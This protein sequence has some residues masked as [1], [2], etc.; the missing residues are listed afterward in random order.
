MDPY[1]DDPYG[2]NDAYDPYNDPN[3]IGGANDNAIGGDSSE[4]GGQHYS[5]KDKEGF[6]GR[7]SGNQDKKF[8]D[9]DPNAAG[10]EA[11]SKNAARGLSG[12]EKSALGGN[13]SKITG[14]GM[15]G[16]RQGEGNVESSSL[17]GGFASKVTGGMPGVGKGKGKGKGFI[18]KLG[19]ILIA[20]C[21]LG[22][23]GAISFFGQMA[24]PFSLIAQFQGNFDSIGTSNYSRVKRFTK[25]IMHGD[26]RTIDTDAHKYIKKHSKVYQLFADDAENYFDISPKQAKRLSRKGKITVEGKGY[27]TYLKF[28]QDNGEFVEVV[29]DPARA[30]GGRVYID[31][32]YETDAT[33]RTAYYEG[34]KTWRQSVANWFDNLC[35]NFLKRIGIGRN[36]FKTYDADQDDLKT[37][38]DYEDT[39]K[40]AT[41]DGDYDGHAEGD[42][43]QNK[44][45]WVPD[46]PDNPDGPG[47]W[48]KSEEVIENT[49]AGG[50]IGLK[51]GMDEGTVAEKIRDYSTRI[52]NKIAGVVKFSKI[53]NTACTIAEII[54]AVSML[55]IANEALQVLQVSTTIFEGVQKS[56]LNPDSV[57]SPI[58]NISNSLTKKKDTKYKNVKNETLELHGSAMEANAVSALY[59]NMATDPTDPSVNSF[60]L[61]DGIQ[62]AFTSYGSGAN[63]DTYKACL[64]AKLAG[65]LIDALGDAISL[66]GDIAAIIACIGGALV[67][68][69]GSCAALIGSIIKHVVIGLS[70]AAAISFAVA[71]VV[72]FL[73]PKIATMVGRDLAKDIGGE[74]FGNALVSGANMYMGKNHQSGG[75]AAA[76][77]ETLITYLKER[78][79][80]VA[81]I[82]QHERDTRSPFDATSPY[83]FMGSLLSSTIPIL[84]S[85]GSVISSISNISNVTTKAFS[86]LMPGASAVTAAKTAQAAADSTHDTCPELDSIGAVGDAFCNPYRVTDF[87]LMDDDPANIVYDVS[88]LGNGNNFTDAEGDVPMINTDIK[89]GNDSSRLMEYIV[90][91][92]ERDSPLGMTDMN[93]ANSIDAGADTVTSL[94]PV[95]GGIADVLQGTHILEKIG[96]VSGESCVAQNTPKNNVGSKAFDWN[97]AKY[98][99]RFIEDQRYLETSG[100]VEKSSVTIA[101]EKY[102][103]EHP[104]DT[105]YEGVMARM[106]GMTKEKVIATEDIIDL[107]MWIAGYEPDGYFP[108]HYEEPEKERIAIE[109]D[110]NVVDLE[111]YNTIED[112]SWLYIKKL[113]YDIS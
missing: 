3:S 43:A 18:G 98:Y 49:G 48:E 17:G 70:I 89:P 1:G 80:Y 16:A 33:F 34:T 96:Y 28:R 36:R 64:I 56:Q 9:H 110:D 7:V 97:E 92:D 86:S 101:L 41:G 47:H 54:G 81:D 57:E 90:Y 82:A 5:L 95:W 100:R 61:T 13:G 4:G 11:R 55:V 94:I 8:G 107:S 91:C 79:K 77:K 66:L 20:A 22:G 83:T 15:L 78:D 69:G 112:R 38:Q 51:R 6:Y 103:E 87:S 75:G 19:P 26:T 105:S 84:T 67:T 104:I 14:D 63:L 88:K 23:F 10:R 25:W 59:G 71:A 72:K 52:G 62:S 32:I 93:I 113:E 109:D 73:V 45:K 102:Y 39:V 27:D 74:D 76:S 31:D 46:D 42:G 68:G 35:D 12:G 99:Q 85:G 108:Y 111:K 37:K 106:T 65:G 24:M 2:N 53:L 30:G 21:G 29:A 50:E 44:D 58:N 40:K 60:N